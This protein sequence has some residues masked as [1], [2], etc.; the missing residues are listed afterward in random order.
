MTGWYFNDRRLSAGFCT[1][2]KMLVCL[3]LSAYQKFLNFRRVLVDC[4]QDNE[5]KLDGYLLLVVS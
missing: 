4:F 5:F 1:A 2:P 3:L